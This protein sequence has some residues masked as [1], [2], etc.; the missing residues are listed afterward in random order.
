MFNTNEKL[1]ALAKK[2]N[3]NLLALL[4]DAQERLNNL[5]ERES[6]LRRDLIDARVTGETIETR[7]EAELKEGFRQD[8]EELLDTC[9][10]LRI[11]S[12]V[13]KS[14]Y[15]NYKDCADKRIETL[16]GLINDLREDRKALIGLVT[17]VAP[18]VDLANMSFSIAPDKHDGKKK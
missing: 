11:E 18:N 1:L 17:E 15:E 12:S 16:E 9:E 6:E 13:A 8:H 5:R 10:G 14:K 4:D 7:V 2:E 3:A